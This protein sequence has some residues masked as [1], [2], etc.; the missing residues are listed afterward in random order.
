MLECL[1]NL[2]DI[3]NNAL[4]PLYFQ[5]LALAQAQ[6]AELQHKLQT[7]PTRYM[8]RIFDTGVY[9]IVFVSPPIAQRRICIPSAKLDQMIQWYH[10]VLNHVGIG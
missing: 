10:L 6:D 2:P 1:L 5:A 4:H 7:D 3:D 8:R 9:L